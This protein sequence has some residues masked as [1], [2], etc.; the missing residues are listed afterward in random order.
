LPV[1]VQAG[2]IAM[3]YRPLNFPDMYL[4]TSVI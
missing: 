4:Q 2:M 1:V 3:H